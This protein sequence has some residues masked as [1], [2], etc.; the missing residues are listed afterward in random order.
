MLQE[1]RLVAEEDLAEAAVESF[2]GSI[3]RQ[4][5]VHLEKLI[6]WNG[7]LY[8]REKKRL[9]FMPLIL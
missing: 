7:R 1:L 9:C 5:E 3:G 8:F 2:E 6:N 4:G